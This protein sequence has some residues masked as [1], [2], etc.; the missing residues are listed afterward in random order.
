[1]TSPLPSPALRELS[2]LLSALVGQL[3]RDRR[4]FLWGNV[5]YVASNLV[6]AG[7]V[8]TRPGGGVAAWLPAAVAFLGNV[9]YVL[10]AE[11]ELRWEAVWR[12]ELPLLG[13]DPGGRAVHA[14]LKDRL[15]RRLAR[16]LRWISWALAAA[17]LVALLVT[18]RASGIGFDLA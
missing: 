9:F 1:M 7:L 11:W 2:P 6:L 3:E 13:G 17:W 8:W 18:L 14:A 12:R 4:A 15:A 16:G 5:I 10:T